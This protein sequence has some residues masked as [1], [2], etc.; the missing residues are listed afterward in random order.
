M[1]S[2]NKYLQLVSHA[3]FYLFHFSLQQNCDIVFNLFLVFSVCTRTNKKNKVGFY[4]NSLKTR[5]KL[6]TGGCYVNKS[7]IRKCF[8]PLVCWFDGVGLVPH[9]LE[10]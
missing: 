9:C 1:T 10:I 7:E 4:T 2:A 8:G 3:G 5:N 6:K